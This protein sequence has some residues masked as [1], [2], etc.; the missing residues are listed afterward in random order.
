[1]SEAHIDSLKWKRDS[2]LKMRG[3]EEHN[4]LLLK[5]QQ[6]GSRSDKQKDFLPG[7][8]PALPLE[9]EEGELG[10]PAGLG[11]ACSVP[12]R[13]P[14]PPAGSIFH[15]MFFKYCLT[16]QAGCWVNAAQHQ[17]SEHIA[18]SRQ[19]PAP[20]PNPPTQMHRGWGHQE[21]RCEPHPPGLPCLFPSPT[22]GR[23]PGPF[24]GL[25]GGAVRSTVACC[26]LALVDICWG[27]TSD[28]P[29]PLD[30]PWCLP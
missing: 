14:T 2:S 3:K 18:P 4:L 25:W 1:M 26:S 16:R 24:L 19:K 22:G 30:R 10:W 15:T 11:W 27:S 7:K 29:A 20:I 8:V 13:T 21:L 17:L 5:S 28:Y 9:G 6:E 23:T 12:C